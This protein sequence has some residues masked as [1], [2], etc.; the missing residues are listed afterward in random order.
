MKATQVALTLAKL[1]NQPNI[2]VLTIETSEVKKCSPKED[3]D[4]YIK[5]STTQPENN[6]L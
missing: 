2:S 6:S 4:L 1:H 3:S 5:S